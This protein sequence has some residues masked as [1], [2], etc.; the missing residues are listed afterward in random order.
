MAPRHYSTE[1]SIQGI[2]PAN[3]IYNQINS[4]SYRNVFRPIVKHA[5]S[6]IQHAFR[7][8]VYNAY[9]IVK[10]AFRFIVETYFWIG[11][12]HNSNFRSSSNKPQAID[13]VVKSAES[14]LEANKRRNNFVWFFFF[15]ILDIPDN[16]DNPVYAGTR[17]RS[18]L[19]KH[20]VHINHKKKIFVEL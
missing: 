1:M 5:Y 9:S 2:I 4:S 18:S 14:Y 6:I 10:H 20:C 15:I 13:R 7:S 3:S 16:P 19:Q 12:E 8:M 17:N 11:K